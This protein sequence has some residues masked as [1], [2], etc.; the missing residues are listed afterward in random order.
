[1][2]STL[3]ISIL[4]FIFFVSAK[5]FTQNKVTLSVPIKPLYG[6]LLVHTYSDDEYDE[7]GEVSRE[8]FKPYEIY[9]EEGELV[10]NV[11]AYYFN[12]E[13]I[14]LEEGIYLIQ[15]EMEQRKIYYYRVKIEA[16]KVT[17]IDGE[18]LESSDYSYN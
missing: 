7:L 17:E 13:K 4:L 3:I 8:K 18:I 5:S 10:L 14:R 2:K 6:Y 16:G 12:P 9:N 1:M 15:A 11:P